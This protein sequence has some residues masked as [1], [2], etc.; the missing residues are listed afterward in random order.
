MKFLKGA[1]VGFPIVPY[2]IDT[3]SNFD[4]HASKYHWEYSW[5]QKKEPN[6]VKKKNRQTNPNNSTTSDD[7]CSWKDT[8]CSECIFTPGVEL[9]GARLRLTFLPSDGACF[10][11]PFTE[12]IPELVT[13]L[14][15]EKPLLVERL[16]RILK[17]GPTEEQRKETNFLRIVSYN[18]LAECY[19]T[20]EWFTSSPKASLP[21]EFRLPFLCKEL[22]S[23]QSDVYCLQEVDDKYFDVSFS[24]IILVDRHISDQFGL[25]L[26]SI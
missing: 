18:C 24:E 4:K 16:E 3:S 23:Y 13:A 20:E 7:D 21:A 5:D 9:I 22:L 1:I 25:V 17:H 14:P 15:V 12:E 6:V 26:N 11:L 8:G 2:K 10:G 19:A